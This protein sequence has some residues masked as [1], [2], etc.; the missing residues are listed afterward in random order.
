[1]RN[2]VCIVISRRK[3]DE[4]DGLEKGRNGCHRL[5]KAAIPG[6]VGLLIVAASEYVDHAE[7]AMRFV[8]DARG[9]VQ[10]IASTINIVCSPPSKF[11]PP[12]STNANRLVME[13]LQRTIRITAPLDIEGIYVSVTKVSDQQVIAELSET[14]RGEGNP[15]R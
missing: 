3:F 10:G 5:R 4:L 2:P 6:N 1:M 15:P 14:C 11:Q 8:A 12:E 13:I 7:K 9:K